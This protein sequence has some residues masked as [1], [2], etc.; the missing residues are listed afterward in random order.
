MFSSKRESEILN[1]VRMHGSISVIDLAR[2]LGVSDQTIRRC[3]KPLSDR[4]LVEKVHGAIVIP[5]QFME[6]PIHRRMSEQKDEK[7]R[8]ARMVAS[9]INDGASIMI[10]SGS[11]TSYV[12]QALLEKNSLTIVT[13]STPIASLL[14]A[15]NGNRVYMAGTEL[16]NHDAA[17]FGADAIRV[18]QQFNVQHAI[19]SVAALHHEKGFL[20]QQH[21][22]AEIA[23]IL[24][25]RADHVI[26]AA[27]HTKFERKSL[28]NI[29]EPT[30][31]DTLVTDK[32]MPAKLEK[33]LTRWG[34]E[35]FIAD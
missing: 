4:G 33:S 23:S 6:P 26:V 25:N 10:D 2:E 30:D 22:E 24:V 21:F 18:F 16:R 29:C 17:A 7:Q 11:T 1:I 27:D 20:V 19:L 9:L 8:I 13:N 15:K 28:V 31:V 14:A 12:A 3:V 5:D 34:I 35:T 32:A